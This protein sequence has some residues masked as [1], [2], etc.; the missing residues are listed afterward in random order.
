MEKFLEIMS[1]EV[2][3]VLVGVGVFSLFGLSC[4]AVCFERGEYPHGYCN[5]HHAELVKGSN[6]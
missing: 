1:V 3:S 2:L 6:R 4:I 5:A